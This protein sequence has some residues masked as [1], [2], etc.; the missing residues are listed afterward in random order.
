MITSVELARELLAALARH[1]LT[2]LP[3]RASVCLS[4]AVDELTDPLVAPTPVP[5][6]PAELADPVATVTAVRD[7]LSLAAGTAPTLATA[8]AYGRAAREL[9]GALDSLT[10]PPTAATSGAAR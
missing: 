9:R 1:H 6:D 7:W 8:L 2:E 5:I 10:P 3:V 4:A